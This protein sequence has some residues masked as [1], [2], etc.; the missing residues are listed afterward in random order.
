MLKVFGSACFV[1]LQPHECKKLKL[2]ARFCY[3][4]EYGIEHKGY[5][6]WDPLSKRLQISRHVTFWEHK[7]FLTISSFRVTETP[8]PLF[9]N[10]NISLFPNE[11]F[12]DDSSSSLTQPTTSPDESPSALEPADSSSAIPF[13]LQV[14]SPPPPHRTSHVSQPSVLLCDYV[15]NSTI[16]RQVLT[17]FGRKHDKRTSGSH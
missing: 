4:L 16:M 15:C 7:M 14:S 17:L 6:C 3:F 10:P 13:S 8:T 12:A 1:L 11:I 5:H 9:T 2:R